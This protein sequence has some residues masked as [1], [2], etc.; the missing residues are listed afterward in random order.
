M[1]MDVVIS[2]VGG[3]GNIFASLVISDYAM[4][5]NLTVIGA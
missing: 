1:K 5:K 2:G 4:K 3:Q